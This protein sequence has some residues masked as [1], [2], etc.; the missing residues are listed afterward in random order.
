MLN[1]IFHN[2]NEDQERDGQKSNAL[3]N[4][5]RLFKKGG[6]L[7]GMISA[8]SLTPF[9]PA[10]AASFS[11]SDT[12]P[13]VEQLNKSDA[14]KY[15]SAVISSLQYQQFKQQTQSQYAGTF[16]SQEQ[17]AVAWSIT[18]SQSTFIAVR[19]PIDGGAGHSC[20]IANFSTTTTTIAGTKSMLFV[21]MPNNNVHA[22]VTVDSQ[23]VLDAVITPEGNFVS[24]TAILQGKKTSLDHQ[25]IKTLLSSLNAASQT[26]LCCFENALVVLAL[27]SPPAIGAAVLTCIAVCGGTFGAACIQCIG[28]ALGI[29]Y[30]GIQFLEGQCDAHPDS[31]SGA[32]KC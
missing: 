18:T 19:I 16:T 7:V 17:N 28:I 32:I 22:I 21:Q 29:A 31:Y 3:L 8:L 24:G 27:A 5:R 6:W 25:N 14:Q 12:S 26:P 15:V 4:R 13:Q 20:Y 30:G 23:Q 9:S 1:K 10:H 11:S 2:Q